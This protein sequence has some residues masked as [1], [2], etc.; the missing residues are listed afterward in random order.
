MG[1]LAGGLDGFVLRPG[2]LTGQRVLQVLNLLVID[3][4]ELFIRAACELFLA[5]NGALDCV[6]VAL[7]RTLQS[8][9]PEI[10]EPLPHLFGSLAGS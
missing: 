10:E 4:T 3:R 5:N 2:E 9:S 6:A 8:P 7:N 1:V